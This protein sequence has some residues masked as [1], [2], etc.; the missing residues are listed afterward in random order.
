MTHMSLEEARDTQRRAPDPMVLWLRHGPY[1]HSY[2]GDGWG[3]SVLFYKDCEPTVQLDNGFCYGPTA[4]RPTGPTPRVSARGGD[5]IDRPRSWGEDWEFVAGCWQ[6]AVLPED[7]RGNKRK[8]WV[9]GQINAPEPQG[10]DRFMAAARLA[11]PL[12]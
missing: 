8:A 9:E 10:S 4:F 6:E 11:G 1:G 5:L 2:F 12:V 3:W 7:W